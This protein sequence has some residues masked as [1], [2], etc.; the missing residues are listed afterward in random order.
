[1][2]K[3]LANNCKK[4]TICAKK[5]AVKTYCFKQLKNYCSTLIRKIFPRFKSRS[6]F[7]YIF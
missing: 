5:K 6:V 1:M 2:R 4:N 3:I 7:K